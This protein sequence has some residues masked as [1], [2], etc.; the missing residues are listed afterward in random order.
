MTPEEMD[1]AERM[2]AARP[3]FAWLT[4][5]EASAWY[6]VSD[7]ADEIGVSRETVRAWCERGTIPGA[8]FYGKEMGWRM[9]RSGLLEYFAGLRRGGAAASAG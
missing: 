9:P 6:R 7:V 5:E 2:L 4:G 1:R 8:V 3:E